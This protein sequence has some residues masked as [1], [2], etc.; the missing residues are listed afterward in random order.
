M[1]QLKNFFIAK[2]TT[3]VANVVHDSLVIF[4]CAAEIVT[5]NDFFFKI[6]RYPFMAR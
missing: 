3:Q 6:Y 2:N 5:C 1:S 4:T